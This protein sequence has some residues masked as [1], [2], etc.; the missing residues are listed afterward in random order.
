MPLHHKRSMSYTHRFLPLPMPGYTESAQVMLDDDLQRSLSFTIDL[1]GD[2]FGELNNFE[3]HCRVMWEQYLPAVWRYGRALGREL[4]RRGELDE[5]NWDDLINLRP[6]EPYKQPC[7]LHSTR[8]HL[9]SQAYLKY[10]NNCWALQAAVNNI[11]DHLGYSSDMDF[12]VVIKQHWNRHW[13]TLPQHTP[14]EVGDTLA[15]ITNL[16]SSHVV[17]RHV[18]WPDMCQFH[19]A[20]AQEPWEGFT[21]EQATSYIREFPRN[22]QAE[23]ETRYFTREELEPFADRLRSRENERLRNDLYAAA[24]GRLN[25]I[26]HLD[27][28]T[29]QYSGELI[30]RLYGT[31]PPRGFDGWPERFTDEVFAHPGMTSEQ[32]RTVERAY[33]YDAST[34]TYVMR[35]EVWN[36]IPDRAPRNEDEHWTEQAEDRVHR[37]NMQNMSA[38]SWS[39]MMRVH[40]TQQTDFHQMYQGEPYAREADSGTDQ[41]DEGVDAGTEPDTGSP[42]IHEVD[43]SGTEGESPV[44]GA[45]TLAGEGSE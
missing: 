32:A 38:S 22:F 16:Y 7:F 3:M 15:T 31:N 4:Q 30:I 35:D 29:T 23:T 13:T 1:L 12:N 34:Q 21:S 2:L 27:G 45:E 41:V 28:N 25:T 36:L 17:T 33:H 18:D 10:M 42:P 8:V 26:R 5:R 24:Y 14:A 9:S 20:I 44:R 19:F 40:P 43:W 11:K 6:D 37:A 39:H